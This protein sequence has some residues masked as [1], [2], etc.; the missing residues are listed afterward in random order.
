MRGFALFCDA[1]LGYCSPPRS[2]FSSILVW[3]FFSLIYWRQ[4]NGSRFDRA[5]DFVSFDAEWPLT[6]TRA[7]VFKR[8]VSM[9]NYIEHVANIY[10][11][12]A[13][14]VFNKMYFNSILL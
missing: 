2:L 6:K 13:S 11:K 8:A 7:I 10:R 4:V 3:L 9:M 1:L 5:T 14:I 12:I